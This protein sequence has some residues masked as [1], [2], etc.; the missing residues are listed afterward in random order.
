[1]LTT[2]ITKKMTFYMNEFVAERNYRGWIYKKM[3]VELRRPMEIL[4]SIIAEM[5]LET[6]ADIPAS[7]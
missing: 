6:T 1:M 2:F 7:F 5:A 4:T 3:T